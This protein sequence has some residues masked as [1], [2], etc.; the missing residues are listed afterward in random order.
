MMIYGLR[1]PLP[2]LKGHVRHLRPVWLMEELGVPYE[3]HFLDGEKSEEVSKD[4][5]EINPFGKVP[6]L[7]DGSLTLFESAA[8]CNYL[9]DKYGKL[10]PEA[11]TP[12]RAL[13][14]Q[15]MYVSV[16]MV[17]PH[18]VRIL[19][20]DFFY[21][22]DDPEAPILREAALENLEGTLPVI[23]AHLGKNAYL[24]GSEFS[25]ADILMTS[26]LRLAAHSDL[27]KKYPKISSYIHRN[28]ERRAFQAAFAL[29]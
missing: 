7:R 2:F 15:W 4:Y 24:M 29:Q 9:A 3:L 5:L 14:D 21:E 22:K 1:A 18:T 28:S 8:I 10:I 20:T 23:E 13:Y 12:A 26:C 17:E 6:S 16:T 11:R 27:F 19:S 25:V